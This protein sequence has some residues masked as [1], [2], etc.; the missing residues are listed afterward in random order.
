MTAPLRLATAG[1][2]VTID[3]TVSLAGAALG[4]ALFAGDAVADIGEA[5]VAVTPDIGALT[6]AATGIAVEALGGTAVRRSSANG[7][8]HWIE[9]RGLDQL[10]GSDVAAAVLS[11]VLEMPGVSEAVL[12]EPI[13]RIVVTVEDSRPSTADLCR[14]V[15]DAERAAGVPDGLRSSSLPGDDAVLMARTIAAVVATAGIGL[16][17]AGNVVKLPQIVTLLSVPVALL[18][19]TPRLR[20]EVEQRI[21]P[22]ATDVLFAAANTAAAAMTASPASATAEAASRGMLVAEAWNMRRAWQ[23]HEPDFH[24]DFSEGGAVRLSVPT[25]SDGDTVADRYANRAVAVGLA[26]A[27]ALGAVTRDMATAGT[28]AMTASPKPIRASREALGCALTRGI[29]ARH[30]ALV[31]SPRAFR[32]LDRVDTLVVDPRALYTQELMI[33]RIN[34]ITNSHRASAWEAARIA[35]ESGTLQVG[36]HALSSIPNAGTVGDVLVSPVRDPYASAVIAEA[37]RVDIRVVSV[38][39]DGLRSLAA[40]FDHL[41][42]IAASVDQAVADVIAQFAADGATVALLTTAALRVPHAA[43]VTVGVCAVGQAPPWGADVFVPDLT[44]AWRILRAMTVARRA[45]DRAVQLAASGSVIG[46]LMLVPGVV[47]RGPAAVSA[48]AAAG[49]RGGFSAGTSVFRDPLPR[50]EPG[51]DWHALPPAEVMRRLPRPADS[52]VGSGAIVGSPDGRVGRSL[53]AA[54]EFLTEMR[55]DLDDPITPLLMTGATASALLGS[56]LDAALVAGVLAANAA[57]SAE[58]QLHAQHVLRALLAI[59]EPLARRCLGPLEGRRH[60]KVS[61][62]ELRP[63]DII[64]VRGGEVVPADARLLEAIDIEIDESTLTGESLPV[65]KSTASTPGAPLAERE[66]MLYG[67]S[68]MLAGTG[69]AVVTAVGAGME[70][71]RALSMAPRKS[72]EI[73]LHT[74]LRHITTRALPISVTGGALVGLL[75]AMRGTPLRHSLASAV[76]VMVAAVPEGLPLVATLAQLASARRLSAKSVLVRNPHSVEAFA[77]LDVVCFDKTGTLSENRLRVR[78]V[79]P[80]AGFV[81]A[82]VIGVSARTTFARPGHRAEHA[83][84]GAIREAAEAIPLPDYDVRQAFLPFQSD[85]PFAAALHENVISIKGAPETVLAALAEADDQLI[86]VVE[87]MSAAGMR[88]LAVAE[89]RLDSQQCAAAISD[90]AV[91]HDLCSSDLTPVGLLGLADTPRAA[92]AAL[93]AELNHRDIGV[94]LITGDHPVTAKAVA[95]ELGLD[96]AGGQ[97]LIGTDWE[98][99]SPDERAAAVVDC[100]V[101]ARMTPEHKVDIVQTLERIGMVTAMVGDGAN[102]AAA[103]RAATIGVGVV[104]RGSDPARSAADVMLLDGHIEALL[105]AIDEGNQ[106]WRRVQSAVSVLLGGNAGEVGFALITSLLTGDSALNTR[107]MLLVNLLTDAFPAAAL[108]VGKQNSTALTPHDEATL[109]REIGMRGI[110][111]AGGATLAW[112]LARPTGTTSHTSTVALIGLVSTQLMQTLVDS[113]SPAVVLTS[114]GSLAVMGAV[115]STPVLSQ[116]FG[117]TPVSPLGWG[118]GLFAAATATT[119][120]AFGPGIVSRVVDLRGRSDHAAGA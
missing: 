77:R 56:P 3:T 6:R 66:G 86:A 39:D 45:S 74:Q 78:A 106:L 76:S 117:C 99:M 12:V 19:Q 82:D 63:G 13:S 67:G 5:I 68:T 51:H 9:V 30:G 37:R 46:A 61:A 119:V 70:V 7:S 118:Q 8:R 43:H 83:T 81:E 103:I 27:T 97:V 94:R 48:G 112:L 116:L 54:R 75:S 57:V 31:L 110:S 20:R 49:L 90:P 59:Q 84:D 92:A 80:V 47:G 44:G 85:R 35:L 21:G 32:L 36:W 23:R 88:V 29:A 114:L 113:N 2:R 18:D 10:H 34:G 87:E 40:G 73:G 96:V 72:R 58:Q 79:R 17:A 71:R 104:S 16:A 100:R 69:L 107:Q 111:T 108:A 95:A 105:D 4:T 33:S 115:I 28:A 1:A 41:H 98:A 22:D 120:S 109:W 15:A 62:D 93:L 24:S 50:P 55:N 25:G 89:R 64:E 91:L 102:D 14:V 53:R 65:T 26:A 11:S 42:P 60:E 101:F 52:A 38:D